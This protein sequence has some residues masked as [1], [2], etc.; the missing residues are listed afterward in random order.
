[1]ILHR[2]APRKEER[3]YL[4]L[5]ISILIVKLPC[6][7]RQKKDSY[8]DSLYSK[9]TLGTI[10]TINQRSNFSE[11]PTDLIFYGIDPLLTVQEYVELGRKHR[12]TFFSFAD[13]ITSS[14]Y[15]ILGHS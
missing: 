4:V 7:V 3:N 5:G 1:M 14:Q 10:W 15:S 8:T 9:N 11:F 2:Q 6:C 12:R 13:I